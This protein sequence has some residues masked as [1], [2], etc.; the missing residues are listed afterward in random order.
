MKNLV[1][2]ISLF[3]LVFSVEAQKKT[4]NV[5]TNIQS[6]LTWTTSKD[7]LLYYIKA[8]QELRNGKTNPHINYWEAYAKYLLYF[9]YD[10]KNEQEKEQA[11]KII[12]EA[13]K[14]LEDID[15]KT[16][17]H[18]ALLS[19]LGGL[20]LNFVNTLMLPFRASKVGKNAEKAI[21]MTPQNIRAYLALGIYDYY[22]PK[23]YGGMKV[24]EETLKKAIKLNDRY[25]PNPY[26]PDWG[27][28]DAYLYLV[29]FYSYEKR[30]NDALKYLEEGL[31]LYPDFETLKKMRAKIEKLN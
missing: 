25:D 18:Y 29:K 8:M 4:E 7:T 17:E 28:Q 10:L 5:L 12:E 11:E 6:K 22:T 26:S 21:Q 15:K 13:I 1:F 20:Q 16:S 31:K 19:L 2:I 27:K 9:E 24:V 3:F 23:M 14:L 30:K